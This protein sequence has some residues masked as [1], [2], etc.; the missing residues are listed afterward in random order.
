MIPKWRQWLFF[1]SVSQIGINKYTFFSLVN[2]HGVR[3]WR[4]HSVIVQ[5]GFS[6]FQHF[7]ITFMSRKWERWTPPVLEDATPPGETPALFP[8]GI[9]GSP[10]GRS[11]GLSGSEEA[12]T[13]LK[14]KDEHS[15]S[16]LDHSHSSVSILHPLFSK[17]PGPLSNSQCWAAV[18][19][20]SLR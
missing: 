5:S 17:N 12:L 3:A 20:Q 8:V 10:P 13:K 14:V 15:S 2:C 6:E 4:Q 16:A 18:C 7:F 19:S 9:Q 11:Q 1:I